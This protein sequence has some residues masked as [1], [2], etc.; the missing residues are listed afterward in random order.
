MKPREIGRR[1]LFLLRR[2]RVEADLEE[3]MRLHKE[4]RIRKLREQGVGAAEAVYAAQRQFGNSTSWKERCRDL[5]GFASIEGFW[6]DLKVAA[7]SLRKSRGFAVTA[8]ATLALGIGANTAVFSVVDAVLLRPLPYPEVERLGSLYT[9][10]Q[11]PGASD[12]QI[13]Q[14]GRTY[15]LLQQYG[16]SMESAAHSGPMSAKVNVAAEG[17]VQYVQQQRV[18]AG[19]FR[20]LGIK[21][22]IGR[23]FTK[24]EDS[25]GG[26]PVAVFSY[27]LWKQLFHGDPSIVGRA[28][29]LKGEPYTIVGVMPSGFQAS[30]PA[31]VWTPLRVSTTGEGGGENYGVIVRLKPGATWQ[32]AEAEVQRIGAMRIQEKK[33]F[34]PNLSVHFTVLPL[35][36]AWTE[37]NRTPILLVWY[38]V[39]LVLLIACLNVAGLLLARG[40]GRTQEIGT[41]M[42]LGGGRAAIIRQLFAESLLLSLMAGI[43]ALGVGYLGMMGLRVVAR[44]SLDVWQTIQLDG[45]VLLASS[46]ITLLTSILF[47]LYPAFRASRIDIRSALVEAGGRAV[48]GARS[49]WPRRLMIVGEIMLGVMLLIAAGLLV[50]SFL[51]LRG[52]QPGFDATNVVTAT[53]PLQDARY[54]TNETVNAL[55]N[56]T[57][58]RMRSLPGVES[59]AV[60][61]CLP[62]ERGLNVRVWSPNQKST[63]T[64]L[65]YITPG[66]FQALRI[67][68]L[69]GRV[70]TDADKK[71]GRLVA[72][73]NQ[74]YAKKYF[75]EKDPIGES[76][77]QGNDRREIVG[78][79]RDVPMKG[80]LGGYDAPLTPIPVLFIPA[81]QASDGLLNLVHVWFS[82]SWIVRSAAPLPDTMAGMQN[83]MQSVE[84]LLPFAGFRSLNEVK[85]TTLAQQRFQAM[86]MSMLAGLALLLAGIGIYGLIAYS[87][88]ERTREFGIRMALG[89]TV[90]QSV[91]AVALPGIALAAVGCVLGVA[92]AS[93]LVR[94]LQNMI[95]G[96]RTTDAITFLGTAL[97]L[98]LVAAAASFL[99]ARR[100]ARLNPAETLR[101]E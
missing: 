24:A 58:V 79:V 55:F 86:L 20:V 15:E 4:L 100:L 64:R 85:S 72:I 41:R 81:A 51:F 80:G 61:L 38:A 16:D 68:V 90:W 3:E 62:Y 60:S 88:T 18:T 8:V 84:P 47:G 99:P 10:Y 76:I 32:R 63:M 31:D 44:E 56:K 30:T 49:L 94:L 36:T 6:R 33:E 7:R 22:L 17:Q 52:Q 82:P 25:K 98:F 1:I 54:Q 2:R 21:P 95:W 43:A 74:A 93:G 28:V 39:A 34:P 37:D 40:A 66:Y 57:L 13:A 11:T 19:F 101:N 23:E 67:P 77:S 70:F 12:S 35:Q 29:R 78:L 71:D 48:A 65:T 14:D 69:K 87:V 73:V 75:P 91:K 96:V 46:A 59:A 26:P 89:A 83:A 92:G 27:R 9:F 5:W 45:R 50:R 42:A 53:L 97:L